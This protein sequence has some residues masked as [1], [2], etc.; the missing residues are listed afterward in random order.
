MKGDRRN[1]LMS[2]CSV[3]GC[4]GALMLFDGSAQADEKAENE[5]RDHLKKTKAFAGAWTTSL[6]RSMDRELDEVARSKI[7]MACGRDCARRNSAPM[8]EKYKGNFEG[9]LIKMKELWLDSY[10][11]DT[12]MGH[13]VLKGRQSDKCPCPIHPAM[14][15][16]S[17]CECSNGHMDE[18]F[19]NALGKPVKVELIESVLRGGPRCSWRISYSV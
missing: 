19:S 2:S 18:L 15:T 9:L 6:I 1:F 7:L 5:L 3:C 12:E 17:Y 14:G 13:I 11:N 8:V 16:K 4:L 10:E